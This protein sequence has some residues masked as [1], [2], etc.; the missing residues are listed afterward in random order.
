MRLTKSSAAGLV[1]CLGVAALV[2]MGAGAVQEQVRDPIALPIGDL[3]AIRHTG[4]TPSF[5][6]GR[7]VG[8]DAYWLLIEGANGTRTWVGRPQ[9][10][11]LE[12]TKPAVQAPTHTPAKK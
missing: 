8:Q 5:V 3:V 4:G 7:L 6:N 12:S 10:L 9:I 11:T 1:A 2:S